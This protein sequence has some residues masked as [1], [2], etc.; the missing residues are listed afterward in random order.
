MKECERTSTERHD[1]SPEVAGVEG[2]I[3]TGERNGGEAALESDVAL[4]LL[5]LLRFRVAGADDLPQHLLHLV[6]GELLRQ[7]CSWLATATQLQVSTNLANVD[8]LHLEVVENVRECLQSNELSSTDVLLTLVLL[9]SNI[10][11]YA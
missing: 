7:L 2:D 9:V 10:T 6:E 4:L 11:P 8:L 5:L 3:N 1:T